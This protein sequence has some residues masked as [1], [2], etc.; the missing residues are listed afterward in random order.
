[1]AL[2]PFSSLS[3]AALTLRYGANAM[4]LIATVA[5]V[6]LSLLI[7]SAALLMFQGNVDA[8]GIAI[9]IAAP[10]L[11]FPWPAKLFFSTFLQLHRVKEELRLRNADLERAMGEIKTLSGFLPLC[12]G[13]KRVRDDRGY[14]SELENF[15]SERLD[16]QMSHGFCP[17]CLARLY[18]NLSRRK[19][20]SS[21]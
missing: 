17:E 9:C 15:F 1:M 3:L 14:W 16:L 2:P 10:L 4:V 5:I 20:D 21:S 12:C 6:V 11:I 18:P 8:L 19:I 13:C 7:T